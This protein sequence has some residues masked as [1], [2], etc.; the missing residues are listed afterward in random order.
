[1]KHMTLLACFA[2][3]ALLSACGSPP[4]QIVVRETAP[5]PTV[6]AERKFSIEPPDYTKDWHSI[7][8]MGYKQEYP[9]YVT[10][11]LWKRLNWNMKL[12]D[13]WVDDL[14]EDQQRR[15]RWDK[16]LSDWV[17]VKGNPEWPK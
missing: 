11:I 4:K 12:S 16:K 17:S 5:M 1:M 13:E 10:Q 2:A 7:A 14:V 8:D 3:L 9:A 15:F 6:T